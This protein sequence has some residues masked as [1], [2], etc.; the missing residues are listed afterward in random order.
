MV[1]GANDKSYDRKRRVVCAH[2][3]AKRRIVLF[4]KVLV[5]MNDG[6]LS[7]CRTVFLEILLHQF[8]NIRA[9]KHSAQLVHDVAQAFVE[10]RPRYVI[11][12]LSQERVGFG[13]E[14]AGIP[15]GEK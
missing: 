6:V 2:L 3:F 9:R 10:I 5:E 1:N 12:E 8:A 14:V 15:T 11:E 13:N 7:L 4:E